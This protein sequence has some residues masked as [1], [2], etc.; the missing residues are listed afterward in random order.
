MCLIQHVSCAKIEIIWSHAKKKRTEMPQSLGFL[1]R[2]NHRMWRRYPPAIRPQSTWLRLGIKFW[3]SGFA[4]LGILLLLPISALP[5]NTRHSIKCSKVS[6]DWKA[7]S[8]ADSQ[9]SDSHLCKINYECI[10]QAPGRIQWERRGQSPRCH[11][12]SAQRNPWRQYDVW[13]TKRRVHS[14]LSVQKCRKDFINVGE[15]SIRSCCN[16]KW[17][18]LEYKLVLKT[19]L[20]WNDTLYYG[21]Q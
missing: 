10:K 21:A 2:E 9:G 1:P 5:E 19:L 3:A 8:E 6:G 18:S 17:D 7:L 16:K 15:I 4:S 11:Q 12:I 13:E 14:S 20:T